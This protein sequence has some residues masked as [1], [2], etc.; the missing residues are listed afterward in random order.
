MSTSRETP[1]IIL[2]NKVSH[3]I[4]VLA[5]TGTLVLKHICTHMQNMP[6]TIMTHL[7]SATDGL[8]EYILELPTAGYSTSSLY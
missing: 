6:F 4:T 7:G 5:R 8:H 3:N 1:C 2:S